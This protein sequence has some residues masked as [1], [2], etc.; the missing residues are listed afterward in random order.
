[1]VRRT[2]GAGD[3]RGGGR[4]AL[5]LDQNAR[6]QLVAQVA[7]FRG[8][9]GRV[10]MGGRRGRARGRLGSW[11][12]VRDMGSSRISARGDEAVDGQLD[13][14]FHLLKGQE[15][16]LNGRWQRWLLAG[17]GTSH[18]Q[19]NRRPDHNTHECQASS[20]RV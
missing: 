17:A 19:W 4:P 2:G 18:G 11:S 12:G 9:N 7:Q 5:Q 10:V 14:L 13:D 3:G 15:G 16:W 20:E 6:F 8:R 1:M